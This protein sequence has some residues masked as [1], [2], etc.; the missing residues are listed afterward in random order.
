MAVRVLSHSELPDSSPSYELRPA[1]WRDVIA[2][3]FLLPGGLAMVW[4]LLAGKLPCIM[5]PGAICLILFGL[6]AF[7]MAKKSRR[8]SNFLLRVLPSGLVLNARSHLNSDPKAPDDP[9]YI[10]FDW[11][12]LRRCHVVRERRTYFDRAS[13]GRTIQ[14]TETPHF[15]CFEF[16]P[17][18][19]TR[20]RA[21]LDHERE[22]EVK[23]TRFAHIPVSL[24]DER[25]LQ[26]YFPVQVQ[27]QPIGSVEPVVEA[28]QAY[29]SVEPAVEVV[30][31][32]TTLEGDELESFLAELAAVDEFAAS[33]TRRELKERA[34]KA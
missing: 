14:R 16:E 10:V 1:V 15:L 13:K 3:F 26:L 33:R 12:D 20:V 32:A 8:P 23:G 31:D 25:T 9:H 22:R 34:E 17:E 27:H 2:G 30:R 18:G 4:G 19:L 28:L 6:L 11:T 7:S 29:T 21:M 5:W 24:R